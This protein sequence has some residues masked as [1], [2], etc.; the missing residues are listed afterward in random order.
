MPGDEQTPV[1]RLDSVQ[2]LAD[3]I[4]PALIARLE[5]SSLGELEVRRHGWRIRLRRSPQPLAEAGTAAP[6]AASRTEAG[7]RQSAG[8]AGNGLHRPMAAVGPGPAAAGAAPARGGR[9]DAQPVALS[10]AVGYY[11]PRDGLSV[12]HTVIAGDVLGHVDVLGVRQEVIAPVDGI[13]GRFLAEPGE[14]VEYGQELL[15]IDTVP[16]ASGRA[17]EADPLRPPVTEG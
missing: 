6:A 14:A 12:G 16:R 3:E 1:E 4:L 11:A 8:S 13:V 2:E 9:A 17:A 15:R 5:S 7:R 10:P